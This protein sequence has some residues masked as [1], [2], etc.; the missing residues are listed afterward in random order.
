MLRANEGLWDKNFK[1][2][3]F[4]DFGWHEPPRLGKIFKNFAMSGQFW[5]L[6][7]GEK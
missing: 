3:T 6:F 4:G 5:L 7:L 1:K 2:S